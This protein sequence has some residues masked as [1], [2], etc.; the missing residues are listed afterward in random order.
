MRV[1]ERAYQPLPISDEEW[2]EGTRE[3][4]EFRER[5][6]G[7]RCTPEG[8]Q[9]PAYKAALEGIYFDAAG[10]MVVEVTADGMTRYDYYDTDG[11]AI[12]TVYTPP[13]DPQAAPYFRDG[14][15]AQVVR[16]AMD[17]QGVQVLQRG[18]A[19]GATGR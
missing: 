1:I 6:P 4:R 17:V 15:I 9:R 10:R 3:F 19:P 16:D 5:F 18:E 2:E 11:R 12:E 13:R 7:T 8:L 14:T